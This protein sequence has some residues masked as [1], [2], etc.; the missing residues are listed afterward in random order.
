MNDKPTEFYPWQ[1]DIAQQWLGQRER[2]AH[3]WLIH[4]LSGVG[5]TQFAKAAAVS[6]LCTQPINHLAC[7][8]CDACLWCQHGN[9]PDLRLI[10]PETVAAA[11][12]G[13][14]AADSKKTLSKEIRVEQLRQLHSWFNTATH[15]GGF[16][17]VVL[18]PAESLNVISAN[19]LLKVL[20]EP[21]A[22]TLFMLVADAPDRLLPTILSRC[23]RLPLP[24][25][26]Q[27][28][29]LKL[30]RAHVR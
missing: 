16:R 21:P 28:Q 17:V 9:H 4:G 30:V 13:M 22:N 10:R 27:E 1:V 29:C 7:G 23:R 18:Y 15:R 3:A 6:L 24:I 20:E 14:S 11:E 5:K 19:A 8:T 25:P 2:F 12:E 26:K